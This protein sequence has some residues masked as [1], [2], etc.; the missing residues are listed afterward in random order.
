MFAKTIN[1]NFLKSWP[2]GFATSQCWNVCTYLKHSV[3]SLLQKCTACNNPVEPEAQRVSYGD[4]HWHAEPQCF[5]C[6]CCSKCLIGQ[7]FMAMQAFL[8]CSVECKKKTMT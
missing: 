2:R 4:H 5:Q 6:S 3:P 7:R 8:F 1:S